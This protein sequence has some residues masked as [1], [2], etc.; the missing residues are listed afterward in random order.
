[1]NKHLTVRKTV[2]VVSTGRTGTQAIARHF[3]QSYLNVTALHEPAPSRPL[4]VLSNLY[5][6]RRVGVHSLARAVRLLRRSLLARASTDLYLESNPFLHGCLDVLDGIFPNVHILHIVRHPLTYIP[7]HINHGAFA[8]AKGL[9]ARYV[10]YWMLNPVQY[11]GTRR[12]DWNLLLPEE[13][14][15]W[16]WTTINSVLNGGGQL[17]GERYRRIRYEDLFDGEGTAFS[18]LEDW[19]KLERRAPVHLRTH[20]Q[21]VERTNQSRR[22]LCVRAELWDPALRRRVLE[23]CRGLMTQYGYRDAS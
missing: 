18:G 10:P 21:Q 9:A 4:R 20:Q 6:C 17:Y 11:E 7:S 19:L 5:L 2:F 15:A 13:K 3:Q 1:M 8:G 16:R 14:L 12:A 23:R 22:Q